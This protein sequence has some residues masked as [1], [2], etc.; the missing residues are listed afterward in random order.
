MVKIQREYEPEG[1]RYVADWKFNAW[2]RG[3]D[4]SLSGKVEAIALSTERIDKEKAAEVIKAA[5]TAIGK[6]QPE[7][8]F[9]TVLMQVWKLFLKSEIIN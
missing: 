2:A 7:I 3:F 1:W 4:S 8:I 6:Q 5:Y 9:V